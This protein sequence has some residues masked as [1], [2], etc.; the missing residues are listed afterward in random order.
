MGIIFTKIGHAWSG[1]TTD[2]RA[3]LA[4][5]IRAHRTG[6]YLTVHA[7]PEGIAEEWSKW[8]IRGRTEDLFQT[9]CDYFRHLRSDVA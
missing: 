9:L 7:A 4:R 2:I 6:V 3:F 5:Q 1:L 8:C